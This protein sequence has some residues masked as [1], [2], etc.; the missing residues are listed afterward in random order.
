MG[1]RPNR[2]KQF[3]QKIKEACLRIKDVS[4][5][6][7]PDQM[8]YYKGARNIC[9]F[10]AYRRPNQ[11]YFECKS[12]Y[13]TSLPFSNITKDQWDGLIRK[14]DIPGVIAG[15]VVWFIDLDLTYFVPISLLKILRDNGVKSINP[16][17]SYYEYLGTDLWKFPIVGEKERVYFKYDLEP[18]FNKA[19]EYYLL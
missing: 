18:F 5:D 1:R 2:G 12:V 19:K 13:D 7:I 9:D 10:I 11:Y 14:S 16:K 17:K 4:I 15:V 3:E 6:R 8:G